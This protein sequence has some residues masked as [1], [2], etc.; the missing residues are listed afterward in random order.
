MKNLLYIPFVILI[1]LTGIL[2]ILSFFIL[3]IFGMDAKK[4]IDELMI[5]VTDIMNDK[6]LVVTSS[7]LCWM[8]LI[9]SIELYLKW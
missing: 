7:I 3:S 2:L 4:S 6:P 5:L 8:M 9:V 1:F